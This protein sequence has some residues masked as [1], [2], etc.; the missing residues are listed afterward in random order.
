MKDRSSDGAAGRV[1]DLAMTPNEYRRRHIQNDINAIKAKIE[2]KKR[3]VKQMNIKIKVS[4][5][6]TLANTLLDRV[7]KEEGGEVQIRYDDYWDVPWDKR[8]DTVNVNSGNIGQFCDQ[9]NLSEDWKL[10]DEILKGKRGPDTH[11][12]VYLSALLRAIGDPE[13]VV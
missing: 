2:E 11:S 1:A 5:L 13:G 9:G 3:R 7:E 6:R 8:Y 12:L 4:D 10:L